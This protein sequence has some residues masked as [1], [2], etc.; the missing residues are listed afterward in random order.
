VNSSAERADRSHAEIAATLFLLR[1]GRVVLGV[2]SLLRDRTGPWEADAVAILNYLASVGFLADGVW[3]SP[4]AQRGA[5]PALT[6]TPE[7]NAPP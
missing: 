1:Q 6:D 7:G 4:E 2:A 5:H 3:P